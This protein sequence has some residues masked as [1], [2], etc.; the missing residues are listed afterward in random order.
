LDRL[1]NHA[2]TDVCY[3]RIPLKYTVI[4]RTLNILLS[5]HC[6]AVVLNPNH[7]LRLSD[8]ILFQELRVFLPVRIICWLCITVGGDNQSF[9]TARMFYMGRQV[10]VLTLVAE[11]LAVNLHMAGYFLHKCH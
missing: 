3:S 7:V 10:I 2:C 1:F 9:T 6:K 11:S 8:L 4:S 5:S